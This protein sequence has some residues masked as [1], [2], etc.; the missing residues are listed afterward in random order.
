MNAADCTEDGMK[1]RTMKI[2]PDTAER[3]PQISRSFDGLPVRIPCWFGDVR[4]VNT[5]HLKPY[6]LVYS[7][8]RS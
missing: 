4:S 2:L 1:P 7:S 3:A 8:M 5:R 6:V